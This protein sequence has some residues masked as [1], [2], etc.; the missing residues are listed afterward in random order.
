MKVLSWMHHKLRQ[1]SIEP[2]KDF[3][4]GNCCTCLSVQPSLDDQ[5]FYPNPSYDSRPLKQLQKECPESF[6][7]LDVKREEDIEEESSNVKPE[8][9]HGF[10]AIGTLG[11]ETIISEPETPMF[12][13]S[14]Q[15][16]TQKETEVTE[17]ELKLINDELEKFLEAEAKEEG[18]NESSGRNSIV[19]T[20]TLSS[21]H[22]EE[23]DAEEHGKMADCPLQ[24]YLFGSSIELPDSMVVLKKE[25]ASLGE[26]FERTKTADKYS[27]VKNEGGNMQAKGKYISAVHLMKKMLKKLHASS[28]SSAA[29]PAASGD[30]PDSVSTKSKLH[31]IQRIFHRKIHPESSTAAKEFKKSNKYEINNNPY[32]GGYHNGDSSLPNEDNRR[33][34]QE[35]MSKEGVKCH[36]TYSN[37]PQ[38]G[39]S[40]SGS[41]EN[42]EH[43]ITTDA[44]CKYR[45]ILHVPPLPWT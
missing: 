6:P 35:S 27:T 34:S 36:N 40:S 44:E 17:N 5:L 41:S 11:F 15:K 22:M 3:T 26:L 12:T 39:L 29:T 31:K 23:S 38:N 4:I 28:K 33:F 45:C 24:G 18:Y 7:K 16:I 20:I 42:R 9:F 32:N 21:K 19:S 2:F 14:S 8:L 37:L 10:L 13:M 25:K 30:A 1:S 43:W